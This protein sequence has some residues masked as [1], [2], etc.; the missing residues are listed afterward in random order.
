MNSEETPCLVRCA[1]CPEGNLSQEVP[2]N[3][4]GIRV[5]GEAG[6]LEEGH[7]RRPK[8]IHTSFSPHSALH[9]SPKRTRHDAQPIGPTE[10]APPRAH[11]RH[12]QSGT[13]SRGR[14]VGDAQST[15]LK[16]FR[17]PRRRPP[18]RRFSEPGARGILAA[19]IP[20]RNLRARSG[21]PRHP[22]AGFLRCGSY[23]RDRP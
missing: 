17:R 2:R 7:S 3:I 9:N 12:P 16:R 10:G 11:S 23:S 15:A 21:T 19:P 4:V 13:P 20:D 14:P 6:L 1:D 18:R 8:I 5:R 22:A